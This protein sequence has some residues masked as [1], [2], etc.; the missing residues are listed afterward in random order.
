[1][2]RCF[3]LL[4]AMA[5]TVVA[6]AAEKSANRA[7]DAKAP[8]INLNGVWRGFVVQ[9]RGEQP[10]RGSVHLELTIKGNQIVA[11]RL[12]GQGGPLGQG[13][14]TIGTERFYLLD[15]TESRTHGKRGA[16]QGICKFG[17]DLMQ[18]CVATPG[19]KRPSDFETKGTQFL[20]V[21][22]RQKQSKP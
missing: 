7:S 17:P 16:Y 1:M 4:F 2:Q 15:A 19:N 8:E 6:A 22:K 20:L 12:D 9:G 3:L 13:S 11:Q 5:F 18:W 10:N 14:Y 21:L